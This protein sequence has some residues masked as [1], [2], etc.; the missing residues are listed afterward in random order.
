M[1]SYRHLL[2]RHDLFWNETMKRPNWLIKLDDWWDRST[3]PAPL[4]EKINEDM[5]KASV[6]TMQ[7]EAHI[8]EQQFMLHMVKRKTQAM[9]DWF[10][11]EKQ[12]GTR[13]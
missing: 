12:N 3:A 2:C 9:V 4:D 8:H 6:E 10:E 1:R 13:T 5:E 11:L 7:I